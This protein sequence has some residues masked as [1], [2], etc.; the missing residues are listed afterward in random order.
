[1]AKQKSRPQ[2][3]ADASG[4][5]RE[6]LDEVTQLRDDI[7][8]KLQEEWEAFKERLEEVKG[9]FATQWSEATGKLEG[10]MSE[11][12]DLRSEYEDWQGNLPE[13]LQSSALGD[14]LQTVCDFN[15]EHEIP[16]DLEF[17]ELDEPTWESMI[18]ID[19]SDIESAIDDAEGADL[20]LGFGKD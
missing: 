15:F 10:A 19:L 6:A 2:R 3:W 7:E 9:E 14:K 16:S 8:A 18:E 13:S 1:M 4:K 17:N 20:P 5:A 11:L 12:N